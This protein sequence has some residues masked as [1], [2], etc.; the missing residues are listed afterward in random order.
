[1]PLVGP[2]SRNVRPTLWG[3]ALL[4]VGLVLL[5]APLHAQ[6]DEPLGEPELP[7]ALEEARRAVIRVEAFGGFVEPDGLRASRQ[8]SGFILDESGLAVTSGRVVLGAPF[9]KVRLADE[10]R[11][12]QARLVGYAECADLALIDIAGEGFPVLD[13]YPGRVQA[14][15][16]VYA[17]GFPLEDLDLTL[18]P[19]AVVRARTP[20]DT[21]WASVA[22][23]IVHDAPID[24]GS[25]GGPLLDAQGRVVGVNHA[26]PLEVG[27]SLAVSAELVAPLVEG[28]VQGQEVPGLGINGQAT[29]LEDGTTG[30]W[31]ASV[32]PGSPADGLG[33]EAGDLLVAMAGMPLAT[34]GTKATYCEILRGR[35]P[36][37]ALDVR[38]LRSATGEILVGQVYGH[39]LRLAQASARIPLEG[40]APS[41]P[42]GPEAGYGEYTAVTDDAVIIRVELP[43]AWSHVRGVAWKERAMELGYSLAAA[44][45]LDAFYST[46]GE[47]GVFIGVSQRLAQEYSPAE[48]L[49]TID[50]A[51]ICT[52]D[53]RVELADGPWTGYMDLWT[54]CGDEGSTFA[55]IALAPPG[56]SFLVLIQMVMAQQA[57]DMDALDH[58]LATLT[59]AL[60]QEE[61]PESD[62]FDPRDHLDLS[63]Y[64][65]EFDLFRDPALTILVP[66]AWADRRSEPWLLDGER[67]GRKFYFAPDVE[68]FLTSWTVPGLAVYVSPTLAQ[69][70]TP[71]QMLD[72]WTYEE[73]C[74]FEERFEYTN[75]VGDLTY[76]GTMDIWT[77]CGGDGEG[78]VT[79]V[80]AAVPPTN[81]HLVLVVVQSVSLVD[82]EALEVGITGFYVPDPQAALRAP[83]PGITATQMYTQVQVLD[84]YLAVEVPVAW[85]E[86][87]SG[88]W[89]RESD[90]VPLGVRLLAAPD[91]EQYQ[92]SWSEPGLM[93]AAVSQE[94]GPETVLD[95]LR[96]DE[97]CTYDDRYPVERSGYP[98]EYDLWVNCGN[99]GAVW[100][101]AWLPSQEA[102]SPTMVLAASIPDG[103]AFQAFEHALATLQVDPDQELEALMDRLARTESRPA[104]AQELAAGPTATVTVRALNVREGPGTDYER[105]GI[106]SRD[107]RVRVLGQVDGCA[108]LK[109]EV[110]RGVVGWISGSQRFVALSHPCEAIPRAQPPVQPQDDLQAPS[111]EGALDTHP[112]LGCYLFENRLEAAVTVTVVRPED[113]WSKAF[114]L[115]EGTRQEECFEPGR[116]TYTLDA[117]S[118]WTAIDGELDVQP[119][120]RYL[121][122]IRSQ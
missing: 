4:M 82:V 116:Y 96:L 3:L 120:D 33:L 36:G 90:Q 107:D 89:T 44:A 26:D 92:R 37:K 22:R 76:Q 39:P 18:V 35:E 59:V 7:D 81:D 71:T 12:R 78:A 65:T 64:E 122:P 55:N 106:V 46:W 103:R 45:D 20:A 105:V 88:L 29:A 17:A 100:A 91:L 14:G 70:Y 118:P 108:W 63:E 84:G 85:G 21:P 13:W 86:V 61:P 50:L 95:A 66:T 111:G 28:L 75:A 60:E 31:V 57:R 56:R 24:P 87:T 51:E 11:P 68:G 6:E 10:E 40:V 62:L 83:A 1:M 2:Q 25:T 115:A 114:S 30:I 23:G 104:L 43:A 99:T 102:G 121:F 58:L 19:G 9:I 80:L 53:H 5:S 93:L 113:G 47:S 119:G 110:D 79:S 15:T 69:V 8:G 54:E 109:V 34:D 112:E 97:F 72:V 77:E 74:T 16:P 73:D 41:D 42:E 52:Y 48:Y 49:D 98:G 27:P 32:D 67:V 94:V 38:V 101:V 117:P